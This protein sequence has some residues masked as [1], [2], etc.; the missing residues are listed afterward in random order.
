MAR[1]YFHF[2]PPY[3][4]S[5]SGKLKDT[6]FHVDYSA[7]KRHHCISKERWDGL[8]DMRKSCAA[9]TSP[10]ATTPVLLDNPLTTRC[11][12]STTIGAVIAYISLP[13]ANAR[14]SALPLR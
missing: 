11:A 4:G 7:R 3:S 12:A 1:Y 14:R 10:A 13:P 8:S 5:I 2:L 6:T 9:K